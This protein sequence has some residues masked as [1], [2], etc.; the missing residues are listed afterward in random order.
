[1][2]D[3]KEPVQW[4]GADY[5][6]KPIPGKPVLCGACGRLGRCRLGITHRLID[7]D[8][9]SY[10][11]VVCDSEY[12]GGPQVAHGGWTASVLDEMLGTTSVMQGQL[13][14]TASLTI[15]F[16][17]PVPI[18]RELEGRAWIERTE[19]SRVYLAGELRLA[20]S[21]ALLAKANGV[22]VARDYGHF[23]RHQQWLEE[24]DRLQKA[25]AE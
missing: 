18:N 10:S 11:S 20:S 3:I 23:E 7:K 21:N 16:I 14:V 19:G 13:V 15:D 24:Q 12:E 6:E 4:A 22:F 8:G 17:K 25:S 1:M 5:Q 2:T 9:V